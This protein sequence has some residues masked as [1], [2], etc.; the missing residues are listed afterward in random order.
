MGNRLIVISSSHSAD[1]LLN[2]VSIGLEVPITFFTK[3]SFTVKKASYSDLYKH[4]NS[5]SNISITFIPPTI[6]A[7][8]YMK[9]FWSPRYKLSD[10]LWKKLLVKSVY[11]GQTVR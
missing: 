11:Q 7:R 3:S 2:S 8:N 5:N 4:K 6:E 9:N 1:V 10:L